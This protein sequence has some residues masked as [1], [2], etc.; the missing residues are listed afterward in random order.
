MLSMEKE[1]AVVRANIYF[2]EQGV[3]L[4]SSISNEEYSFNNGK[5]FNSGI[6]RHFRHIIDHY[7]SFI[8]YS[9]NKINYDQ[10]DRDVELEVNRKLAVSTFRSIIESLEKFEIT[11]DLIDRKIKVKSNEGVTDLNSPWSESSV[12]RELQFL[13]SHTVHHYALI[14]I[15]LKTMDVYIPE[16]FGK[17]PSTL[18]HE[19]R[20]ER[21]KAS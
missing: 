7:L 5:Y 21:I 13:I 6:G 14:G 12:R 18:K 11:P 16:N 8:H 4:L 9:N 15:I 10:R 2:L 19:L 1:V 17:A 3:S 20:N